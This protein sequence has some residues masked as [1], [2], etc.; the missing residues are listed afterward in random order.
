M[1]VR[2]SSFSR[3]QRELRAS[4]MRAPLPPLQVRG[5]VR[6]GGHGPHRHADHEPVSQPGRGPRGLCFLVSGWVHT[7]SGSDCGGRGWACANGGPVGEERSPAGAVACRPRLSGA[8]APGAL[9][10]KG[11]SP[12][13][14]AA[15]A[16]PQVPARGAR[17]GAPRAQQPAAAARAAKAG[18]QQRRGRRGSGSCCNQREQRGDGHGRRVRRWGRA[19]G[20]P[21][22]CVLAR[23][24]PVLHVSTCSRAA[25]A[26]C[27]CRSCLSCMSP[28]SQPRADRPLASAGAP[29]GSVQASRAACAT[30]SLRRARR[31]WSCP[32]ITASTR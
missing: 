27:S 30:R 12:C 17:D 31:W 9:P 22:A 29:G 19:G 6:P 11:G 2:Q 28:A 24:A 5:R 14:R 7:C 18:C 20:A 32:A 4:S 16:L 21:A 25:G 13:M 8:R 23:P 3:G 10:D 15:T 26:S 1:F